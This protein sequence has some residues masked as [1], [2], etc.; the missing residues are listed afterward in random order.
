MRLCSNVHPRSRALRAAVATVVESLEG[1]RLFAFSPVGTPIQDVWDA[2]S[3]DVAFDVGTLTGVS[4]ELFVI[5]KGQDGDDDALPPASEDDGSAKLVTRGGTV[6]ANFTN[7]DS[8]NVDGFGYDVAIVGNHVAIAAIDQNVGTVVYI[9]DNVGGVIDNISDRV[10]TTPLGEFIQQIEEHGGNLLVRGMESVFIVN[11]SN[12][13]QVGDTI[14]VDG[15]PSG[16][17]VIA[18]NGSNFLVATE[19][20]G[21]TIVQEYAAGVLTRTFDLGTGTRSVSLAYEPGALGDVFIGDQTADI[22]YQYGPAGSTSSEDTTTST[23]KYLAPASTD[24][25]GASLAISGDFLVI[26]GTTSLIDATVK[27]FVFNHETAALDDTLEAP[28]DGSAFFGTVTAAVADGFAI[29]D[30]NADGGTGLIYFYKQDAVAPT[31]PTAVLDGGTLTVT[32]TGDAESIA[33][34]LV[35]GSVQV[36]VVSGNVTTLSAQ[37]TAAS[38]T[39]GI[40]INGD[41]GADTITSDSSNTFATE[42]HGGAGND[43]ITGGGGNDFLFGDAGDDAVS[44]RN[45]NDVALGGSG[46]DRIRGGSGRDVLIGGA[47]CDDL[48]GN[49]DDDILIAGST[50]FDTGDAN[51]IAQLVIIRD[52]W[53]EPT[54]YESRIAA[55]APAYLNDTTVFDDSAVDTVQGGSGRD[56]FFVQKIGTNLDVIQDLKKTEEVI[57]LSPA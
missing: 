15:N 17:D 4:G 32:G 33:V 19:V 18:S 53:L 11:P 54:T 39:G 36:S 37:F 8:A 45:G 46:N 43:T 48:E 50:V 6:L 12:A 20:G 24:G 9:Y 1:R 10:I 26:G 56:W 52:E 28:G 16:G 42:I 25:F 35:N 30:A 27:A 2:E 13:A 7:P 49:A 40:V 34:T 22:V 14:V 55:L 31:G 57:D 3:L 41:A 51:S 44:A 38:I 29:G 47:D 21:N 23:N 5:G